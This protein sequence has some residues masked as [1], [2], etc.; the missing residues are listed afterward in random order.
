MNPTSSDLE[1]I[2]KLLVY[3]NGDKENAERLTSTK[4]LQMH[5]TDR[6]NWLWKTS[7]TKRVS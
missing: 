4:S 6:A 5:I 2:C 3:N 7:L 1:L